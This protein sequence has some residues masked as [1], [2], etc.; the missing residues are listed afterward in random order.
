MARWS[1]NSPE[2]FSHLKHNDCCSNIALSMEERKLR[3]AHRRRSGRLSAQIPV[4]LT[5]ASETG[6][7]FLEDA[8]TLT[9]SQCGA[10][11]LSKRKLTLMPQTII[12][13][14]DTGKEARVRIVGRI[15]DRTDGYVYAVEFVDPQAN[16]WETE[17]PSP[18][19]V[20]RTD[21]LVF[22]VC[23]CCRSSEAVELGAPKLGDFEATHGVLLYCMRCQAMTRWMPRFGEAATGDEK[24]ASDKPE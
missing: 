4:Q 9:L 3:R 11:I 23:G 1:S 20:D 13:R 22:L 19:D 21:E 18:S 15:G 2:T 24:N 10:S 5:G 12:R 7:G 6:H 8:Q 16:L 17:F 14:L